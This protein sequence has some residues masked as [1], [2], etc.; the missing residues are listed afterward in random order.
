MNGRVKTFFPERR[1][2][3]LTRSDNYTSIFFHIDN[4]HPR[5]EVPDVGNLVSF[6]I[7]T[8]ADGREHAVDLIVLSSPQ[9]GGR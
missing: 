4:L 8:R 6:E 1:F 2:G 9:G 3:F 7:A 5:S